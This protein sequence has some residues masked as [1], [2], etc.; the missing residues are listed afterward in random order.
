MMRKTTPGEICMTAD[1]LREQLDG[2]LVTPEDAGYDEARAIFN[3]MHDRR[4]A[5]IAV[6]P[7]AKVAATGGGAQWGA[8]DAATQE[9]GLHTPGGRVTTTGVG[10]FTLG[11]GMGW[12]SSKWGLTC[13]SLVG[14]EV[15]LAD[16]RVVSASE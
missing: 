6:D 7:G 11:G 12:T 4:P 5:L 13:D 8:Y 15:V 9:H 2:D 3:A 16:G 1:A 10:G 14:A